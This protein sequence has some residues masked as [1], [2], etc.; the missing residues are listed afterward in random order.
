MMDS[1]GMKKCIAG[2][3]LGTRSGHPTPVPVHWVSGLNTCQQ[4]RRTP[5]S[6]FRTMLSFE[7]VELAFAIWLR[8]VPVTGRLASVNS[9][10]IDCAVRAATRAP[11]TAWLH[12]LPLGKM[13]GKLQ[14]CFQPCWNAWELLN[15]WQAC[16]CAPANSA[17]EAALR[18]T[19]KNMHTHTPVRNLA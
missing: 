10:M 19:S 18:G 5:A 17:T 11:L 13:S 8:H 4:L 7:A 9:A 3:P 16:Q 15:K 12:L 6:I 2:Q 14:Q 1:S